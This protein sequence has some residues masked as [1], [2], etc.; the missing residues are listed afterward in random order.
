MQ[1]WSQTS[2]QPAVFVRRVDEDV[3][4]TAGYGANR[5]ALAY[6]VWVY[7]QVDWQN[8]EAD[9]YGQ[10]INPIL[11]AIDEAMDAARDPSGKNSLGTPGIDNARISGKADIADGST[12]GQAL[13]VVPVK[14]WVRGK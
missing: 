2:L 9:I 14:V 8:P 10:V 1:H 6:E 5:Y 13:M 4:Q 11:D 7:C 12:D 3:S